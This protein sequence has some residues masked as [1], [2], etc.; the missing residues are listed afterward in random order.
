MGGIFK[1]CAQNNDLAL[2]LS[3]IEISEKKLPLSHYLFFKIWFFLTISV[4]AGTV[5][6]W[7]QM[8]LTVQDLQYLASLD[9]IFCLMEFIPLLQTV[10]CLLDP[11]RWCQVLIW[12]WKFLRI[13]IF[14]KLKRTLERLGIQTS[15]SC[16]NLISLYSWI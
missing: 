11:G 2:F 7:D 9:S 8:V 1:F 10:W 13:L 15:S 6:R 5:M 12:V 16:E 3:C 14:W 4:W